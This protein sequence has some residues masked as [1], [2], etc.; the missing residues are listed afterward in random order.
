[1]KKKK[2]IRWKGFENWEEGPDYISVEQQH[3]QNNGHAKLIL[4]VRF[5]GIKFCSNVS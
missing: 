4:V 2:K 1:M 3:V 5:L